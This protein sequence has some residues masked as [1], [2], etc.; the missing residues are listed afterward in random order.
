MFL[1][2][3]YA[4]NSVTETGGTPTMRSAMKILTRKLIF[5]FLFIGAR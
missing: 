5:G 3:K 1:P 2:A 4:V